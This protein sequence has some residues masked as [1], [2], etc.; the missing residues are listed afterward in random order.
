MA[1]FVA[2]HLMDGVVDGVQTQLFGLLGQL[3]LAG[4]SA[5][6]C[7][8]AH[9]QILLGGVGDHFAQQLSELGGVLC[10]LIGGLFPVQA[11]FGIALPVS[12]TGHGQIHT[13][14]GALALKVGAQ[15]FLDLLGNIGSDAN[16][17]FGS[18]G[19]GVFHLLELFTGDLALGADET[20]GDRISF[21]NIT[22]DGTYEF[23]HNSILHI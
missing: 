16:Y 2:G 3:G 6:L 21:Q 15:A 14:F 11:D 9:G 22:T 1:G 8:N 13:H 23:C 18:P 4:G 17:V 19:A 10:L 20:G 12:H 7:V 5:V